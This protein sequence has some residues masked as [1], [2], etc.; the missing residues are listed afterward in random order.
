MLGCTVG[1]LNSRPEVRQHG[2]SLRLLFLWGHCFSRLFF[3]LFPRSLHFSVDV[4]PL[5]SW[6]LSYWDAHIHFS[7]LLGNEFKLI[8]RRPIRAIRTRRILAS[9]GG[10]VAAG[11]AFIR[12]STVVL[13]QILMACT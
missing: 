4:N 7:A 2:E 6:C 11:E 10:C 13:G 5:R 12:D 1:L 9:S 3:R 8:C